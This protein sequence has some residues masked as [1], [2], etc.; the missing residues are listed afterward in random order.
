MDPA[1]IHNK[2]SKRLMKILKY[3]TPTENSPEVDHVVPIKKGGQSIGFDNHQAL[4][5][6]CHK[7]K[8]K[9]DNSGPRKKTPK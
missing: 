5:Y 2:I 7:N 9:L 4:C 6:R 8:S 3:K 1:Q